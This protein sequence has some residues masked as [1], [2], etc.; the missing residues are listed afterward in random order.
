KCMLLDICPSKAMYNG[1]NKEFAQAYWHWFFLIQPAPFPEDAITAAPS[2]FACKAFYDRDIHGEAYEH[3]VE[4]FKDWDT[5]HGMCEDYRASSKEDIDQQ[6][7]DEEVG[8]K[9]K[10]LIR[11]LWGKGGVV[12]RLFDPRR[13]WER[14]SE[15]GC[16]DEGSCAMESGHYVPEEAPEDLSLPTQY[17]GNIQDHI[18]DDFETCDVKGLGYWNNLYTNLHGGS[19]DRTDGQDIFKEH[20]VT[21]LEMWMD[22]PDF[23][24]DWINHGIN[25]DYF[26]DWKINPANN[27][28]DMDV[29]DPEHTYDNAINTIDGIIVAIANFNEDDSADIRL[30]WSELMFN[31]WQVAQ[32]EQDKQHAKDPSKPPGGPISNLRLIVQHT[33]TNSQTLHVM[34]TM[35][36][37]NGYSKQQ[38]DET[39]QHW[40]EQSGTNFFYAILGTPNVR[41]ALWLCNDH[42]NSI[43]RKMPKDVY[44]RWSGEYPDIWSSDSLITKNS[45]GLNPF[46]T[47][48]FFLLPI[49]VTALYP[50]KLI[51]EFPNGT[52]LENIAVRPTG[53]ILTTVLTTPDLYLIQPNARSPSPQ[54]I[55][56]FSS[57]E[58]L[59]GITETSPDTFHIVAANFST[60]TRSA[61][62][63]SSAIYRIRFLS[64]DSATAIVAL[65]TNLPPDIGLPNG[66]TTLNAH[67]I[68][69]ADSTKG[70]ILAI[71]TQ[72][73]V[74]KIISTDP[75]LRPPTLGGLGVNGLKIANGNQLFFTNTGQNFLGR[76]I[77][78]P[79]T[80]IP[81][82]AATVIARQPQGP[83]IP[84]TV[85]YDDF[86]IDAT[87]ETVFLTTA[88]GNSITRVD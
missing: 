51:Y 26:K 11:V 46:R 63:G 12:D 52:W 57:H 75:L 60:A 66:L 47:R 61:V 56:H 33:I 17:E 76:L 35:Y 29:E 42:A 81:Q 40:S 13:E 39:W 53:F 38:H 9:I 48:F 73:G 4:Q 83:G 64:P 84:A 74:S 58:S 55:H 20:Y 22:Y 59:L 80:A 69:V 34:T 25:H 68:L 2:V 30:P 85:Q 67:T 1:T 71:D 21:T 77:I 37:A 78:D 87:G 3:Y 5:V 54:L 28:P 44:T 8:R 14:V 7:K 6:T 43:G 24:Q 32:T 88:G 23:K 16:V 65:T 45:L 49:V 19:I 15:K 50:T 70:T 86:A 82:S 62:P 41:G 72:T 10:C 36:D 31:L 18:C 79:L 27:P